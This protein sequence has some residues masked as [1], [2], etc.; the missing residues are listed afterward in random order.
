MEKKK[1]KIKGIS[2]EI[3]IPKSIE[4]KVEENKL[5]VKS[6]LGS[7]EKE[8]PFKLEV[9]NG[10]IVIST[11]KSTRREGKIL[12]TGE[13]HIRNMFFGLQKPFEYKLQ[14]CSVH[15]PVTAAVSLDKKFLTIKNFLGE[16]IE[17]KA[18]LM[19]NVEVEVEKD[20]ITVRSADKEAAGQTAANIEKI[21]KVK[22]KDRRIFQD[23]I[24]IIEKPGKKILW[25]RR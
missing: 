8:F 25:F 11:D 19:D 4:V 15:F 21:A 16:S 6:S 5:I 24:F 10:K 7:L 17:R 23:G 13:A 1:S 20:I 12:G 3:E 18:K 22:N 14:I 9:K 2:K